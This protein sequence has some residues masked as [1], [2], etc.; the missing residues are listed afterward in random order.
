MTNQAQEY[1]FFNPQ[2]LKDIT[3]NDEEIILEIINEFISSSASYISDLENAL[4]AADLKKVN[5]VAHKLKG[6]LKFLG[7]SQ[8]ADTAQEI[9]YKATQD[10]SPNNINI[11]LDDLKK[12]IAIVSKE[13]IDYRN[14]NLSI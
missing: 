5:F 3:D 2:V 8:L 10:A 13:V 14:N 9:E 12:N 4:A 6:A 7:A 1:Q 11:L